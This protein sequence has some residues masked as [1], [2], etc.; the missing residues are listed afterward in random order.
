MRPW[1]EIFRQGIDEIYQRLLFRLFTRSAKTLPRVLGKVYFQPQRAFDRNLPVPKRFVREDFGLLGFGEIEKGFR[2]AAPVILIQLAI[3][4]SQILAQ[5]L[6][7]C[8]GVDQLHLA[9]PMVGF[10]VRQYPDISRDAG[11]VKHV[12]GQGDDRLQPVVLYDPA[13]DVALALASVASEQRRAVV[14]LS[15]PTSE[16]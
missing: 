13:A 3:L 6:E 7:P 14:H 8:G 11:V 12:Q 4:L 15:H 2:N 9:T 10:A 1:P 16:L 5:R